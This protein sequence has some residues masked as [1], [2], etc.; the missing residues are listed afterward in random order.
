MS[1]A[2][3]S[4]LH[5][6]KSSFDF[7]VYFQK[8]ERKS[9]EMMIFGQFDIKDFIEKHLKFREKI[10]QN[11]KLKNTLKKRLKITKNFV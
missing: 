6:L 3:I 10:L 9:Y 1:T 11:K 8:D 7:N 2:S 5:L 4:L